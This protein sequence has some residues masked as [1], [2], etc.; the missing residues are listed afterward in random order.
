V[1]LA[2]LATGDEGR[3]REV[4][5]FISADVARR[6]TA[7]LSVTPVPGSAPSVAGLALADGAVVTVLRIGRPA[8]T[9]KIQP[10]ADRAVLCELRNYEVAVTG[11][12]VLATG[13]FDAEPEGTGVVWR[14]EVVPLIDVGALYAEAHAAVPMPKPAG[15]P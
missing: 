5:G 10:G 12:V 6:L 1:V 2:Y 4:L 7:L 3:E 8:G 9:T 15:D 14:G 11:G 13:M